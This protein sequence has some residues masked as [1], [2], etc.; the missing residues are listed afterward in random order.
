VFRLGSG[1]VKVRIRVCIKLINWVEVSVRVSTTVTLINTLEVLV[2]P[3]VS[4]AS[5][6]LNKF[7]GKS[8][9]LYILLS[10]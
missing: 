3:A 8:T 9:G 6:H 10:L 2:F 5:K 1:L 4:A 7:I